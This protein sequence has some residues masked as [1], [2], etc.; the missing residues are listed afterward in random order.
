MRAGELGKAEALCARAAACMALPLPPPSDP[1][2]QRSHVPLLH[3][4]GGVHDRL[5]LAAG[6]RGDAAA[7]ARHDAMALAAYRA[8][9]TALG[10]AHL[11]AFVVHAQAMAVLSR[12]GDTAAA[13]S[14]ERACLD[15][16]AA[17]DAK[18]VHAAVAAVGRAWLCLLYTS[19]SPRDS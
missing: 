16:A 13:A 10:P 11:D 2:P 19:P 7:S 4:L 14:A 1:A 3:L 17:A 5:S 8:L 18:A 9:A 12:N 15:A 6:T